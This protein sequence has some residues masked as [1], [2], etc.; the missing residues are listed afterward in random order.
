MSQQQRLARHI[1]SSL[2]TRTRSPRVSNNLE[3]QVLVGCW[4]QQRPVP[5]VRYFSSKPR[6]GLPPSVIQNVKEDT[7]RKGQ[8]ELNATTQGPTHP[9]RARTIP[10]TDLKY[11]PAIDRE[12]LRM[13][14][15]GAKWKD[16]DHEL[17]LPFSGSYRRYY[18]SL[19]PRIPNVWNLSSQRPNKE[20]LRRLVYL[21][22]VEKQS[23]SQ[24]ENRYLMNRPW[25]TPTPYAPPKIQKA[26]KEAGI[27]TYIKPN[28]PEL[29]QRKAREYRFNKITIH[30]K[31]S[32]F[33]AQL[34]ENSH[35]MNPALLHRAVRQAVDLYGENWKRVAQDADLFLDQW[36][37]TKALD[38]NERVHAQAQVEDDLLDREPL[39]PGRVATVFRK[40]ERKGNP[41][42]LQDDTIMLRKV[43]EQSRR[44]PDILTILDR[45]WQEPSS[46]LNPGQQ[47]LLK[48]QLKYWQEISTA[49]G[50][51]SPMHCKRRWSGLR[52]LQ[53][54]DKSSESK[55]WHRLERYQ[56]WMVWYHYYQ[57][58]KQKPPSYDLRDLEWGDHDGT[59]DGT[60]GKLGTVRDLLEACEEL[61]F[62]KDIWRWIRHRTPDECQ[63]LF[64]DFVNDALDLGIAT[65][66]LLELRRERRLK[67]KEWLREWS[68]ESQ[69]PL[70][71]ME[72]T[73]KTIFDS[74]ASL[75]ESIAS[76]VA[77]PQILKVFTTTKAI[78]TTTMTLGEG[79]EG[80]EGEES[81]DSLIPARPDWTEDRFR[82]LYEVV[83]QA[84]QESDGGIDSELNWDRI[85][86]QLKEKL[87]TQA[88]TSSS[89]TSTDTVTAQANIPLHVREQQLRQQHHSYIQVLHC[90]RCW[91]YMT[92]P[93]AAKPS[94]GLLSILGTLPPP[95]SESNS[96]YKESQ[97]QDWTD[98]LQNWTNEELRLLR[99]GVGKFGTGWEDIK[100][101]FLP[102]RKAAELMSMWLFIRTPVLKTRKDVDYSK[103]EVASLLSA[104]ENVGDSKPDAGNIQET[105]EESIE[106]LISP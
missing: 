53:Y 79:G 12:I 15:E 91:R 96:G 67:Q 45:P 80:D 48:Q 43:L 63:Q 85:T 41:W 70:P 90:K 49:V 46:D 50:C 10:Q 83:M 32:D 86:Q 105:P 17:G 33:K 34:S 77:E 84:R 39:T 64:N 58:H 104:L 93:H 72:L 82:A 73:P 25:Q 103:P 40:V 42:G 99:Q 88:D 47:G 44:Q 31:Y 51:H 9:K 97:M 27:P 60:T 4:K 65:H 52:S 98:Q 74:K 22:D 14:A 21:I 100:E 68:Q 18:S 106:P 94:S 75:L 76:K 11:D 13:L 16:I 92:S 3:L 23:P 61:S 89:I 8:L 69:P 87:D 35:R 28:H 7:R 1:L 78:Q 30:K 54:E 56:F 37:Y 57:Q 19:D 81:D 5:S 20:M 26:A 101:H 38:L 95:S 2:A 6:P 66:Q 36:T 29:A 55:A 59:Q 102:E 71:K 24:I 62:S